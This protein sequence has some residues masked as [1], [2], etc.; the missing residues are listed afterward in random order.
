MAWCTDGTPTSSQARSAQ[1]YRF[2]AVLYSRSSQAVAAAATSCWIAAT[3]WLLLP[4]EAGPPPPWLLSRGGGWC[5]RID[6]GAAVPVPSTCACRACLGA[7]AACRRLVIP[8]RSL[9][10]CEGRAEASYAHPGTRERDNGVRIGVGVADAGTRGRAAPAQCAMRRAEQHAAAGR[11]GGG[12]RRR[13]RR[14]YGLVET[15]STR[16]TASTRTP[17]CS[18]PRTGRP[19]Q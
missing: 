7:I 1:V 13:R 10:N 6:R 2:S 11:G 9:P 5:G 4:G 8:H 15:Y 18:P 19:S 14:L 3:D 12:G 16:Y 17:P